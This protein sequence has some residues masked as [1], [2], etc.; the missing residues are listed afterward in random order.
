MS[1]FEIGRRVW[2]FGLLAGF[3]LANV[4]LFLHPMSPEDFLGLAFSD[5]MQSIFDAEGGPMAVFFW[6]SATLG[7]AGLSGLLA[8]SQLA[9]GILHGHKHAQKTLAN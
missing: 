1:R 2:L 9:Q 4:A 8:S 6:I 7:L 5:P 3:T